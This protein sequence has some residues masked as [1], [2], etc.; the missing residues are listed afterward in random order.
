MPVASCVLMCV[1][2]RPSIFSLIRETL[3]KTNP[4]VKG[5]GVL[6]VLTGVNVGSKHWGSIILEYEKMP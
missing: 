3:T 1:F 2:P 5:G 4:F 6:H